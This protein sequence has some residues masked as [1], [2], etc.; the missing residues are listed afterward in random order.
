[1][2]KILSSGVELEITLAPFKDA[3]NLQK[4]IASELKNV[5]INPDVELDTNFM[6]DL[7]CTAVASDKIMDA[8]NVCLKR[9]TYNNLKITDDIWEAV[10]ARADY[11]E[12]CTEV[13]KENCLPFVK[14]LSA[15]FADI[16]PKKVK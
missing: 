10:E 5:K 9:C 16:F 15:Q 14:G 11:Y 13:I 7:I 1:M 12:V 4:A 8:L 3:H 2:K 6:K